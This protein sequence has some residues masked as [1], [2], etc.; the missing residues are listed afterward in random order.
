[1]AHDQP[2]ADQR[3]VRG[4]G[5]MLSYE[6][7]GPAVGSSAASVITL[8]CLHGNS[9]HRGVWRP[10]ARELREFRN[11][12]LDL[13]GHGDS[14]HVVPPAYNP[15]HHAAD[16]ELVVASLVRS[17]YAILGHSAGALV[18]ARFLANLHA[19]RQAVRPVAFVWVD[20]DPLVPQ[21]QVDYFHQRVASAARAFPNVEDALAGFRRMYPAVPQGRLESFVIEG[22]R[23]INGGWRM[24]LDPATYATWEPGDLRP[25]LPNILIPTLV[26]RGAASMGSSPDGLKAL[27]QRLPRCELREIEGG[28]HLLL[29]EYPQ[30]IAAA[31]RDFIGRQVHG[32]G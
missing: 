30:E 5:P 29:L 31:V 28:S 25:A 7:M 27:G 14:E 8:L 26:L 18:A 23:Q 32:G 13:R 2:N 15:E 22:L 17:P 10:V 6:V 4:A 1:M 21:W 11:V 19:S 9:S 12:L 16:I 24:K 20:I 3:R